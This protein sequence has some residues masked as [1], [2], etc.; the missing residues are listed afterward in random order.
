MKVHEFTGSR[1]E[2]CSRVQPRPLFLDLCL[3]A[4]RF[5]VSAFCFEPFPFTLH[6]SL[7][8]SS[9]VRMFQSSSVREFKSL[10]L[11]HVSRLTFH[12]FAGFKLPDPRPFSSNFIFLDLSPRPFTS[13]STFAFPP[14]AFCFPPYALSFPFSPVSPNQPFPALPSLPKKETPAQAMPGGSRLYFMSIV[15]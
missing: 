14:S 8:T 9:K 10:L 11:F 4:F 7:F 15:H 1:V 6:L 13:A 12:E 3:S 2:G 5:Q